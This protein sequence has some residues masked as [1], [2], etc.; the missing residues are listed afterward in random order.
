M[1]RLKQPQP[2]KARHKGE[3]EAE[4]IDQSANFE[5]LWAQKRAELAKV[6]EAEGQRQKALNVAH[7]K[8]Q[9]GEA[10]TAQEVVLLDEYNAARKKNRKK[11]RWS[12]RKPRSIWT[13]RG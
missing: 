7:R 2:P 12:S 10:L 3:R 4:K 5:E 9:E 8:Q 1:A 6:R 13:M 11:R